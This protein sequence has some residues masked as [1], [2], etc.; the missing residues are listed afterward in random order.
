MG[1]RNARFEARDIAD[2]DAPDSFDLITAF[3]TIHDQAHPRK[4]LKEIA[5]AL[6]P[7][8]TFLI[9]DIAASSNVEENIDHPLGPTIYAFSTCTA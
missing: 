1:L 9:V 6:R 2:L 4:V 3:D 8:G 7:D 5:E